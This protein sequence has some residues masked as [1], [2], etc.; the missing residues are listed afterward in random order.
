MTDRKC[1]NRWL[2]AWITSIWAIKIDFRTIILDALICQ[3]VSKFYFNSEVLDILKQLYH[4]ENQWRLE[5]NGKVSLKC[6]GICCSWRCSVFG[7]IGNV[8]RLDICWYL[9][10]FGVFEKWCYLGHWLDRDFA[11]YWNTIGHLIFVLLVIYFGLLSKFDT[12]SVDDF[13]LEHWDVNIFSGLVYTYL[14]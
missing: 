10:I 3:L 6:D 1:W 14:W 4:Q 13:K 9:M 2:S 5:K 12:L 7:K 8:R 11:I